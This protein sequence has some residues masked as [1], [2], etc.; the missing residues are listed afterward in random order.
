MLK[1][2]HYAWQITHGGPPPPPILTAEELYSDAYNRLRAK[3][4]AKGEKFHECEGQRRIL[5]LLAQYFAGDAK[6][7]SQH[8]VR[9]D[10]SKAYYSLR[11]GLLI[12]GRTG[13]NKTGLFE[14]FRATARGTVVT[15]PCEEAVAVYEHRERGGQ[16]AL[17]KSYGR[18]GIY[19]FDDLGYEEEGNHFGVPLEVME[20]IINFRYRQFDSGQLPGFATHITTNLALNTDGKEDAAP[21]LLERYGQRWYSRIQ[22][23]FN[24]ITIPADVP[25]YRTL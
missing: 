17:I 24:I 9:R 13:R 14:L 11:K 5:M 16:G 12:L 1:S 4:E 2:R 15:V 8:T 25:D 22:A 21:G 23:M 18:S 7:E 10:N 20:Y 3:V 6:F 19:C